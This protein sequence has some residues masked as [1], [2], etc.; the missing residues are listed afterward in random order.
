VASALAGVAKLLLLPRQLYT[1]RY[2]VHTGQWSEE[3]KKKG[4]KSTQNVFLYQ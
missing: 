3:K 4:N 1:I 2:L